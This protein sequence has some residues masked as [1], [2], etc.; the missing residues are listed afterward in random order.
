[1][2]VD[3]LLETAKG[4][5]NKW[6]GI[7]DYT[8]VLLLLDAGLRATEILEAKIENLNLERRSLKIHGKGAK[9]RKVFFGTQTCRWIK[10][11]LR[12]REDIS[13]P[14]ISTRVR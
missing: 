2:K 13:N 10:Q 1:K 5:T 6:T 8:M 9:D 11:W 3:Q 7:R 4:Y 14:V 12:I